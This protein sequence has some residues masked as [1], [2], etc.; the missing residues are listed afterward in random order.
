MSKS[1]H[2]WCAQLNP[3]V[4]DLAGN[5]EL[6]YTAWAHGKKATADVV[7]TPELAICA[8]PPE[9]LLLCDS[10]ITRCR[11][12]VEALAKRTALGPVLL[13]GTPWVVDGKL[14]NAV[15]ILEGGRV[16]D[17]A[18]KMELPNYGVFDEKRYFTPAKAAKVVTVAGV[19]V[20]IAI[21]EDLWFGRVNKALT[22]AGAEV[23]L[24]PNASP[25]EMNKRELRFAT[26]GERV[27]E[28]GL[29][30]LYVNQWGGQDELLFDGRSFAFNPNDT[31]PVNLRPSFRDD[32]W[33]ETLVQTLDGWRFTDRKDS[34]SI[35]PVDDLYRG[36]IVALRDYINKSGFKKGVV[37][38]LSGGIDSALTAVIAVDALGADRVVGVLM[39]SPYSSDHSVADALALAK[40]LGIKTHTIAI[41]PGMRAFDAMLAPLFEGT[42][43]DLTEENLQARLRGMLLMAF[44]NK[45]GH[46]VLTTGNKSEMS[47]GYATLYGDMCGGYNVL[48]DVWKTSVFELS[49]YVNRNGERIPHN[50]IAKPPSAELRPDQTD[51]QSLPEYPILDGILKRLVED[52][53]GVDDVIANGFDPAT[54][55]RVNTLL[56]R[57]EYKRRQAPPGAKVTRRA[58]GKDFRFPIVNRDI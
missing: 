15:A 41:E 22:A 32:Q 14:Y 6:I 4:G 52:Y 29:P 35:D 16:V 44:S 7:L 24:S 25:Y 23:I 34:H 28:C 11:A 12:A 53:A 43:P 42:T 39:P 37:I 47:V 38:G 57:S 21:C 36:L 26:I 58:F 13:V 54:V 45:F 9:D 1:L 31:Y 17:V 55:K 51:Q 10:F 2:I 48:K 20:G 5:A 30:I 27:A 50:T 33:M 56:R 8:Y 40:N 3:T 18:C 49:H 46:M 19:K